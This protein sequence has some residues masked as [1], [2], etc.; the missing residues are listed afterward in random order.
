M[1][2]ET[3]I[4]VLALGLGVALHAQRVLDRR[5][6]PAWLALDTLSLDSV[7]AQRAS[8][9]ERAQLVTVTLDGVEQERRTG[10]HEEAVALHG[11]SVTTLDRFARDLIARLREWSDSARV[12]AA[13]YPLA[14]LRVTDVRVNRLRLLTGAWRVLHK[15]AITSRERYLLRVAVLV[16]LLGLLS[17]CWGGA[18]VPR[19]AASWDMPEVVAS[20]VRSLAEAA[21][22]TYHALAQSRL[23]HHAARRPEWALPER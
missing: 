3:M 7:T 1:A 13:L 15:I 16:R 10:R 6:W 5:A 11:L 14:P 4:V 17:R 23:A 20:D 18:R 12:L 21:G 22:D 9:R 8:L 2:L 19:R